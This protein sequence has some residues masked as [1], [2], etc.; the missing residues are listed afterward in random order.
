MAPARLEPPTVPRLFLDTTVLIKAVSF[1]RLPFEVVRLG[2]R[3]QA[4]IVLATPVIASAQVHVAAKYPDQVDRLETLLERLG[5]EEVDEPDREQV[6]R[7]LHLCRDES[8]VPIAL[9][10]INA[11][12]DYLV[13]TDRDLTVVDDST[14][15][16]REL[17]NV[18]TP[19]V[20]LRQVFAWP[21][22]RIEGA[23]HRNW[24]ELSS[25]D[26]S[27]IGSPP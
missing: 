11:R 5:H 14:V 1:P 2:L 7:H 9:A 3:R 18:I 19:L 24:H 17:V 21:E 23:I 26:W 22:A 13:T 4:E 16:L 27:E 20:L 10:A 25:E 12:V 6:Y 15:R 8:D